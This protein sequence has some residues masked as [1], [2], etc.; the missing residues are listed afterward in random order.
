MDPPRAARGDWLVPRKQ[1]HMTRN[2][3]LDHGARTRRPD[4]VPASATIVSSSL[5]VLLASGMLSF[6]WI[7]STVH[8]STPPPMGVTAPQPTDPAMVLAR[9]EVPP[10]PATTVP[11][12]SADP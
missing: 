10:P 4:G 7:Y 12:V 3:E 5:M 1:S 6:A 11:V 8:A 2:R 9:L